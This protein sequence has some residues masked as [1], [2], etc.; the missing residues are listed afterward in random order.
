MEQLNLLH[1]LFVRFW[2]MFMGCA[3]V[4]E[5]SSLVGVIH[6]KRASNLFVLANFAK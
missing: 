6:Q 1:A 4:P 3:D 2:G 5:A